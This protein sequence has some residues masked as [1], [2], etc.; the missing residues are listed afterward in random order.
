MRNQIEQ[1]G[2]EIVKEKKISITKE[3]ADIT[4]LINTK[5]FSRVTARYYVGSTE[6]PV[7]GTYTLTELADLINKAPIR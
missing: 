2:L 1:D 3:E 6:E 7:L 4:S 5:H